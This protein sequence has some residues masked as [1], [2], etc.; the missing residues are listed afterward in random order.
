MDGKSVHLSVSCVSMLGIACYSSVRIV[1]IAD[2]YTG[3]VRYL[4]PCL[5]VRDLCW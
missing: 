5:W 1:L 2:W 3:V 4:E